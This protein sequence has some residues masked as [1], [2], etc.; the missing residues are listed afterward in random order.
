MSCEDDVMMSR[1]KAGLA[2]VIVVGCDTT[3][4]GSKRA[5]LDVN[6]N[7]IVRKCDMCPRE[8]KFACSRSINNYNYNLPLFLTGYFSLFC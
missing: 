5:W 4:P 2:D 8:A 7:R 3:I 1:S 6:G